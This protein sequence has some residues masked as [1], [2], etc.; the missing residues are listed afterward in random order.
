VS[1]RPLRPGEDVVDWAVETKRISSSRAVRAAWRRDLA[2]GRT[3]PADLQ[4]LSSVSLQAM[5]AVQQ[6]RVV[7]AR[8]RVR[9]APNGPFAVNP[10]V[11]QARAGD[12]R[13][14]TT[15]V[16]APTLFAGGDLPPFTA[17]GLDPRMLLQVPWQ[18]RHPVAEASTVAQAYA[19]VQRYSGPDA[20]DAAA[21]ELGGHQGNRAYATRVH[22]WQRDLPDPA[23][24]TYSDLYGRS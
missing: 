1:D 15:A 2:A 22:Q 7:E 6:G 23:G 12:P 24:T 20:E 4:A 10:L 21:F 18:A 8:T 5:Q 11:A 13:A 17:S 19:L 16:P 9:S 3:V 14:A